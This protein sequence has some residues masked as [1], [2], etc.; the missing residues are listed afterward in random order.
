MSGSVRREDREAKV[1]VAQEPLHPGGAHRRGR[2]SPHHQRGRRS[3]TPGE[4][5]DRY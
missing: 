5:H 3:P 1:R 4:D 2:S